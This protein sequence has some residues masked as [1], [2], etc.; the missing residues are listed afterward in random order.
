M[1]NE[2]ESEKTVAEQ[3]ISILSRGTSNEQKELA[4]DN[5]EESKEPQINEEEKNEMHVEEE[6]GENA[7]EE[8][9]NGLSKEE[10]NNDSVK[11][12]E[13]NVPKEEDVGL[14]R[15]EEDNGLVKQEEHH[16]PK[17]EQENNESKEEENN[18]LKEEDIGLE[19]NEE[20]KQEE[21]H[22]PKTEPE[23][24]EPKGEENN[25]PKKEEENSAPK[26]EE[27]YIS[28]YEARFRARMQQKNE[29]K[30]DNKKSVEKVEETPKKPEPQKQTEMEAEKT[31]AQKKVEESAPK[32]TLSEKKKLEAK[33]YNES[34]AKNGPQESEPVKPTYT[35]NF[36][37]IPIR[38]MKSKFEEEAIKLAESTSADDTNLNNSIKPSVSTSK[39]KTARKPSNN[40]TNPDVSKPISEFDEDKPIKA[41]GEY[42]IPEDDRPIGGKGTYK[43]P[44]EE[45]HQPQEQQQQQQPTSEHPLD[46]RPIQTSKSANPF[47]DVPVGGGGFKSNGMVISEYPEGTDPNEMEQGNKEEETGP[48]EKRIKSKIIKT[49]QNAFEELAEL[50]EKADPS[51]SIVSEY[52]GEFIK[53]I[54]ETNPAA[55]EKALCALKAY[56][57]KVSTPA[58][59][60]RGSVKVL[61]DKVIGPGKPNVKKVSTEVLYLFFEKLDKHALFDGINESIAAKNQK[62]ACAGVQAVMELLAHYGPRKLEFLKPFLGSVEK[63]AGSTVA[64]LRNEAMNFYKEALRW[65]REAAKPFY[66]KLKKQQI[67]ELDK[68]FEEMPKQNMVPLSGEEEQPLE[69]SKGN[70]KSAEVDNTGLDPYDIA[71]PVDIFHRFSESWSERVLAQQKWSD[72]K[73]ML[74]DLAKAASVPKLAPTGHYH[75][76][77]MLKR[78][79]NDNNV[80]VMLTAIRIYGL[81]AKGLRKHFAPTAKSIAPFIL[82]KF[83]EKKTQVVEETYKTFDMLFY[84]I[85]LDD[86]VDDLKE[87]LTDKNAFAKVN[88]LGLIDK[89]LERNS[90][91]PEKCES[92]FNAMIGTLKTLLND[93]DGSVRNSTM[94]TLGKMKT[95]LGDGVISSHLSDVDQ[96]KLTKIN[97]Q[98]QKAEALEEE[99]SSTSLNTSMVSQSRPQSTKNAV[100]STST[101]KGSSSGSLTQRSQTSVLKKTGS[102]KNLNNTS[103]LGGLD[104][105]AAGNLTVDE[106]EAKL[107]GLGVA[108]GI[109]KGLESANWK[110]KQAALGS[111]GQWLNENVDAIADCPDIVIR[112]LKAKLKDWKE[113]NLGI[114]KETFAIISSMCNRQEVNLNKRAFFYVSGLLVNNCQDSKFSE[115]IYEI[116]RSFVAQ[117]V[118]KYVITTLVNLAQDTK[119]TKPNPKMYVELCNILGKLL[120]ELT[121]KFFPLKDTIDYGKFV[122]GNQNPQCRAAA[123]NLFKTLYSQVGAPMLDLINDIPAQTLKPLQAELEKITVIK[124]LDALIKIEFRGEVAQEVLKIVE[125]NPLDSLPRADISKDADKI[126]KTL[127]NSDWKVRKEGLE[128]LEQ[129]LTSNN[130][131]ISPNG[132][133]DLVNALKARLSDPNKALVRSF[134]GFVAKFTGALGKDIHR[135]S[136]TL[137]IPLIS[138]LSDKQVLIRQEAQACLEKIG[139][140][141]GQDA[142]VTAAL[143]S[144]GQE[145]PEMRSEIINLALKHADCLF[146]VDIKSNVGGILTALQ[147]KNKEIRSNAEK[148]LEKCCGVVGVGPFLTAVKDLKPAI[149]KDLK[150]IIT[151]YGTDPES[152]TELD[153]S[154][155]HVTNAVPKKPETR[156]GVRKPTILSSTNASVSSTPVH[157]QKGQGGNLNSTMPSSTLNSKQSPKKPFPGSSNANV[158]SSAGFS[159][160]SATP[161]NQSKAHL[162]PN[163]IITPTGHK[164]IRSEEEKKSKWHTDGLRDDLIER[165]KD[166]LRQNISPELLSRMFSY[167]FRKHIEA[168]A[169]LKKALVLELVG[170]IDI[171]DLI[172]RWLFIRL[173][174]NINL[175]SLKE[176]VDYVGNLVN[177]LEAEKYVLLPFE[178]QVLIPALIERLGIINITLKNIIAKIIIKAGTIYPAAGIVVMLLHGLNSKNP[179]VR[180]ECLEV[181]AGIAQVYGSA[182]FSPKDIKFF[183][184]LLTHQD[185]N[186]K[187]ATM[188]LLVEI[189]RE[190]NDDLF[191]ILAD[192]PSKILEQLQTKIASQGQRVPIFQDVKDELPEDAEKTE[193]L[194]M[195]SPEASLRQSMVMKNSPEK[196]GN[197]I[198]PIQIGG[199]KANSTLETENMRNDT[200]K[201]IVIPSSWLDSLTIFLCNLV[202]S[203]QNR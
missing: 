56:L 61:I 80:N 16:E 103:V 2:S 36:D 75:I 196:P 166:H 154:I 163:L 91:A 85:S 51:D 113:S 19:K 185:V 137:I 189:G 175:Q 126:I 48:L 165:L 73:Q 118:P 164:E 50:I 182:T 10:E 66:S 101:V 6:T 63:L 41:Q 151:K 155:G 55:Q 168:V 173:F 133:H 184:K 146:K 47:D 115:T 62:T 14:E 86:I 161:T 83:R 156:G 77:T 24:N 112:F 193:P 39:N 124:D 201:Q 171:L 129:L 98:A 139:S 84:S 120:D 21:H 59:D 71:D 140:E 110:D 40:D 160:T 79:L 169:I 45:S 108:E 198:Q 9:V 177:I 17:T 88:I 191:V 127:S 69:L 172:I 194:Y 136:K 37:D 3:R 97:D 197:L 87:A 186:I 141:V 114:N 199:I 109:L 93:G 7:G 147:D 143:A 23:N 67:E 25:E 203:T 65:M 192:V 30:S 145:N 64:P 119:N 183:G 95:I 52:S 94:M 60:S 74:E 153:T 38:P 54:S 34:L 181:M 32:M 28:K 31:S 27:E 190:K 167:D 116:T 44:N 148:L 13:N 144:I 104:D 149:Q 35:H 8:D 202:K 15:N 132:L 102:S 123:T 12:E 150:T 20:G 158:L 42:N 18:A 125:S 178:A 22:E 195:N 29:Q 128:Q 162:N 107:T 138:C 105:G 92:I 70:K 106:A 82:Q 180:I 179:K 135:Y 159:L 68:F 121:V 78:L 122:I 4:N 176:L 142:I 100:Q 76:N 26:E 174:D 134:I 99:K 49:R 33:L 200:Q 170:T 1:G 131:R 188:N 58:M 117:V 11:E 53:F 187:N 111:F 72:K 46:E 96:N 89:Y 157:H 43:I 57:S 130:N 81:L 90:Q 5:A 152:I